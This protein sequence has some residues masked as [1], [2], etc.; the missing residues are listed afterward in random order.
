MEAVSSRLET[1]GKMMVDF[2]KIEIRY[3]TVTG[4][5]DVILNGKTIRKGLDM[6]ELHQIDLGEIELEL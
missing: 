2:M 3:N 4:F 5:Y 1:E 6:M